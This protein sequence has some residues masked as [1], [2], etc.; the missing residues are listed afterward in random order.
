MAAW[1]S[2]CSCRV[3]EGALREGAPRSRLRCC[4]GRWHILRQWAPQQRYGDDADDDD[5]DDADDD[6]DDDGDGYDDD[7]GGGDDDDGGGDDDDDDEICCR[8]PLVP[9]YIYLIYI[10]YNSLPTAARW[11]QI[12][13]TFFFVALEG[14]MLAVFSKTTFWSKYFSHRSIFEKKNFKEIYL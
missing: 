10:Y 11:Q 3:R 12:P 5:D 1:P 13:N 8:G 7:D 6:A 9:K 14:E 2:A 4:C